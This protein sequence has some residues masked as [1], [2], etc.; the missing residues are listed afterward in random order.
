MCIMA[1][2]PDN[3]ATARRALERWVRSL[4]SQKAAAER[5]GI[6]PSTLCRILQGKPLD[7]STAAM[8]ER[9]TRIP[10]AAWYGRAA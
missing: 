5:I 4:G 3:P 2:T 10:A 7:G 9:K 8:I 6:L 1:Q